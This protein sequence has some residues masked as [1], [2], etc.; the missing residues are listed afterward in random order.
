M[1]ISS[2]ATNAH[3]TRVNTSSLAIVE[4]ILD[5]LP[6][7]GSPARVLFTYLQASFA[8]NPDDIKLVSCPFEIDPKNVESHKKKISR[9][10]AELKK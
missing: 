8:S 5:S 9:L 10:V 1:E 2:N 6:K 7:L 3:G 4:L